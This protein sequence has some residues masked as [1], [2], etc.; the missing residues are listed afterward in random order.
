MTKFLL[1]ILFC[2]ILACC[3]KKTSKNKKNII[4]Y[5]TSE[6]ETFEQKAIIKKENAWEIQNKFLSLRKRDTMPGTL[7]FA[8]NGKYIF[9]DYANLKLNEATTKGIQ[10]D[11]ET[12]EVVVIDEGKKIENLKSLG[13]R[14]E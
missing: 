8:I 10:V 7:Y 4:Y 13:W 9:S 2:M 11:S 14:G 3:N 1:P 6:F 12:G 5:G